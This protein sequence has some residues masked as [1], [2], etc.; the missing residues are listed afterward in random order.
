[1]PTETGTATSI[2]MNRAVK[3]A[4]PST[5]ARQTR[6]VEGIRQAPYASHLSWSRSIP[7]ALRKRPPTA[8]AA[9]SRL[10][11]TPTNPSARSG[12]TIPCGAAGSGFGTA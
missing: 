10:A 4:A 12:A 8:H 2:S 5:P 9:A 7:V 3:A 6:S 1:M 11:S